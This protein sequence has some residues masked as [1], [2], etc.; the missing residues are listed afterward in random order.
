MRKPRYTD[1]QILAILKQSDVPYSQAFV[2][3]TLIK[4]WL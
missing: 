4:K 2:W 3:H 1:S